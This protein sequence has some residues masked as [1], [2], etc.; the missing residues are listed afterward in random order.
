MD[1]SQHG[2]VDLALILL[3]AFILMLPRSSDSHEDIIIPQNF[4]VICKCGEQHELTLHDD[5]TVT[6]GRTNQRF[7]VTDIR[8]ITDYL[9]G[10]FMNFSP[11][12]SVII[13]RAS[14]SVSFGTLFTLT[15]QLKHNGAEV[16]AWSRL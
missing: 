14:E 15:E 4:S 9:Y 16:V 1:F 8:A 13:V 12:Y 11:K 5:E 6:F 3:V 7:Y 10:P 2:F